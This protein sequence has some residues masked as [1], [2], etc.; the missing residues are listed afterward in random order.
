MG[1]ARFGPRGAGDAESGNRIA[2]LGDVWRCPLV[3]RMWKSAD[4]EEV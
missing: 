3:G 1:M 2:T 4:D